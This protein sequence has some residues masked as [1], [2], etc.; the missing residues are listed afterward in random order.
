MGPEAAFKTWDMTTSIGPISDAT[1]N[2]GQW[3]SR[4]ETVTVNGGTVLQF[5]TATAVPTVLNATV[6]P[7]P[8][9][10]VL[11]VIGALGLLGVR[12]VKRRACVRASDP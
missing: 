8:A 12:W 10:L 9:S 4:Y 7:E 11:V 6:L 1:G 5:N 3:D 2:L